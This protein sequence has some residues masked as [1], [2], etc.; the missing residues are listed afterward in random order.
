MS[1]ITKISGIAL[2]VLGAIIAVDNTNGIYICL[3]G[4]C[5]M[6]LS[7]VTFH[8]EFGWSD[9]NNNNNKI[10]EGKSVILDTPD[11]DPRGDEDLIAPEID[12]EDV[13]KPNE[14]DIV[15]EDRSPQVS[16]I[17]KED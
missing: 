8:P 2:A 10:K 1:K 7:D 6:I 3:I 12:P 5:A 15:E 14:N 17:L 13:H 11:E 9:D 16:N 4:A